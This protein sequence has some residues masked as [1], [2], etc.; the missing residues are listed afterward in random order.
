MTAVWLTIGLLAAGTIAIKATGPILLG[1]RD[2]PDR[3]AGVV[4]L[5]APSLL[6]ALVIVDTFGADDHDLTVDARA[7]GLVAAAAALIARLPMLVVVL[8]AAAAT[9]VVRAIT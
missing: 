2:L 8:A 7:A 9:A 1:E 3:L 6:A 5:L 4:A